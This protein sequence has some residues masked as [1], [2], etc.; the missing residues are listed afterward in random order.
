MGQQRR[1][2]KRVAIACQGGGSHSAFSAGALK[3]LLAEERNRYEIVALSGTSGGAICALFV[4]YALLR[5][6]R[7]VAVR[8][9]ESFWE[10]VSAS[11]PT[12]Q[13]MND[14]LVE[15][16][17]MHGKVATPMITPYIYPE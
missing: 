11:S 10:S 15:A 13:V 7:G 17:R 8:L 2:T 16:A 3:R 6:D 9:L 12:E 5:D 14:L 4:W 1:R